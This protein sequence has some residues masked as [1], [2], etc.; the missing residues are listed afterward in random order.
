MAQHSSDDKSL[1]VPV[2]TI[3]QSILNS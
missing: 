2:P 3:F 1:S